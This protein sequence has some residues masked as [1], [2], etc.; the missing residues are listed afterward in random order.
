MATK[1]HAQ[2]FGMYP[3]NFDKREAR[4]MACGFSLLALAATETYTMSND[5]SF[6]HVTIA[7]S[8]GT[9]TL[10]LP[11]TAASEGRVLNIY[12][13]DSTGTVALKDAAGST[14]VADLTAGSYQYF[15][16]G[17]AWTRVF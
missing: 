11:P 8:S 7:G 3:Q 17:S 2:A 10:L 5:D 16:T 6:T 13:S 1:Y 9:T 14:V 4:L 15:C 12:V